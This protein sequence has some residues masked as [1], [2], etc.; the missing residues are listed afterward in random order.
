MANRLKMER[1]GHNMSRRELSQLVK[2]SEKTISNWESGRSPI[3]SNTLILL[4][5]RF[6]CS[7]D[8]LLMR[9]ETRTRKEA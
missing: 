3:P 9:S 5:D 7:V 6:G 8:W 2:A 4:C 1:S